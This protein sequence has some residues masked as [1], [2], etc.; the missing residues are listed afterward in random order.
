MPYAPFANQRYRNMVQTGV[1]VPL[2]LAV[3]PIPPGSRILE[4][5]CGRGVAL[6]T[7]ASSCSPSRLVGLDIAPELIAVARSRVAEWSGG[8][9]Y[10]KQYRGI[11]LVVG[12]ARALPFPPESFDVVIDFGTCYHIDDAGLALGEISRVLCAGGRF[13][14]ESRLAQ[15]IAHPVRTSGLDLP[16]SVAPE[17][18]AERGAVLWATR[19]KT[20]S[21]AR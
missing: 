15:R 16:W 5:G 11:E 1:E 21:V 19:R 18:R 8:R 10:R 13:I 9:Q 20:S 14:H 7:L 17:L 2:L 3:L 4:I 6:P 12:D